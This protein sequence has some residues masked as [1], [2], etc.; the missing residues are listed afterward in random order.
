VGGRG[1]NTE[2]LYNTAAQ[3]DAFGI[4]DADMAWLVN[5]VRELAG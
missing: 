4:E 2:Y 3:L 5:R 1:P